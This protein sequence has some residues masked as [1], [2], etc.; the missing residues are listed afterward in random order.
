MVLYFGELD[1][2]CCCVDAYST[3]MLKAYFA[4]YDIIA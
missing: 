3:G 2:I 4:P 1:V